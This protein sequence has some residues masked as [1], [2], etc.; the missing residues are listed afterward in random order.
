VDDNSCVNRTL[1]ATAS[2]LADP[3]RAA[4]LLR[5]MSGIVLPAGELARTANVAP[6]TA[7]EHLAKLVNARFLNV[8]RQGRHRY[9][10]LASEEAADAIE[11]L[12]VLTSESRPAGGESKNASM[13]SLGYARTCYGHLAGWLGV[14][15]TDSLEEKGFIRRDAKTYSVTPEGR[16]WFEGNNVNFF[17][18]THGKK[19]LARPC[20]DWTE[21][22]PHIAG[23]LGC[24]MYKR[25]CESGWLAPIRDTRAVRVTVKGKTQL[26][27]LLRI[28]L[29]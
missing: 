17:W 23:M 12:L 29:G 14:R 22:R 6:Q 11:A 19:N 24:A 13:G 3:G 26:W 28:P 9:Y 27:K 18:L 2:L 16:A 8:E 25:F 1:S 4:I 15:I 7:S 5:L 21:R 10:R 20:L